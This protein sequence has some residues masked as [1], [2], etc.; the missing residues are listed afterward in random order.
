MYS[1]RL[2]LDAEEVLSCRH[3]FPI[4]CKGFYQLKLLITNNELILFIDLL[5]LTSSDIL[6]A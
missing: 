1:C 3:E 2:S 5:Q 6:S 4:E